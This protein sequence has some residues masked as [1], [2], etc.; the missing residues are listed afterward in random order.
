MGREQAPAKSSGRVK[1]GMTRDERRGEG[2]L[3]GQTC[4]VL[5]VGGRKTRAG[6]SRVLDKIPIK[7][8]R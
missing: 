3:G 2:R 6:F 5:Q 4:T 8:Q 7:I 1:V